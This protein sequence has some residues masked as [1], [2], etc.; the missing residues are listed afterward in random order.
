MLVCVAGAS[1]LQALEPPT[2]PHFAG[3]GAAGQSYD[4]MWALHR[5]GFTAGS[6][7]AWRLLPEHLNPVVVAVID[8]GLDWD[9]ED[10]AWDNIWRNPRQIGDTGKVPARNNYVDDL[11]GW[12]FVDGGAKPWDHDGHGTFVTGEIAATWNNGRGI[13]GVNPAAKIM[14]LRALNAFG[15]TRASYLAQAIVYAA[16]NGARVV[17]ISVAG[18]G[19]T[20]AE[21]DAV[22]YATSKGMLLVVAAGNDGLE[23]K[24]YG[25]AGLEGVITVGATDHNDARAPFSNWGKAVDIVAPGL[26]ILSLRARYTDTLRDIPGASY[27]AGGAY[28]GA[29]KR[30]Y[31][32]GG[33]SF[34]APLVT[35]VAS[36]LFAK[37]PTLTATDVKRI[38]LNSAK[39][40]GGKGMNQFTGYGLLDARAALAAD[41]NFFVTAQVSGV[42]VV[43]DPKGAQVE[44]QGTADADAFASAEVE[45][46]A[47]EAPAAFKQVLTIS[48]PVKS[49]ALGRIPASNFAGSTV[50]I[51]RLVVHHKNGRDREARFRLQLG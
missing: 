42:T 40:V 17:N 23:L 25:L 46:G 7:S 4:D 24:D 34:S 37:D 16:D 41:R 1:D 2:D 35:G 51:V 29:D 6:D 20:K 44:V 11:I 38:L 47:G 45:L 8:T 15:N 50:W 33:T 10:I 36:L 22:R 48:G 43:N 5:I 19:L 39:E 13:V 12:D 21:Q 27:T 26:D 3:K 30:Y 28:V 14:V 49:A 31:V 18:Q 9:H 32:A